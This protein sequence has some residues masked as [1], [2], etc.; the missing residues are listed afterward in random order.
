MTYWPQKLSTPIGNHDFEVVDATDARICTV[1]DRDFAER[2]AVLLGYAD[3]TPTLKLANALA[4]TYF[5]G[6]G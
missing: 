4:K 3:G 6:K 1:K 5:V 2:I